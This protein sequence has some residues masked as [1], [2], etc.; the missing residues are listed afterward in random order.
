MTSEHFFDYPASSNESGP[1]I[2]AP[3]YG[4]KHV[5]LEDYDPSCDDDEYRHVLP[6]KKGE[7]VEVLAK[8]VS[9][10]QILWKGN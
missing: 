3:M 1:V 10:K 4:K 6:L 8:D 9:G 5:V 7:K 2:S